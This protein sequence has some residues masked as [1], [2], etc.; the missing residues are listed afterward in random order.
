MHH[1]VN[2]SSYR[3]Y[4]FSNITW[5]ILN[6]K[7]QHFVASFYFHYISINFTGDLVWIY[8]VSYSHHPLLPPPDRETDSQPP[9]PPL[10]PL[11]LEVGA[12]RG[13]GKGAS[14]G[15]GDYGRKGKEQLRERQNNT[16][17]STRL[18]IWDGGG[19]DEPNVSLFLYQTS[20]NGEYLHTFSSILH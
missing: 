12:E 8:F 11:M 7:S 9:P 2:I 4:I 14:R 18:R 15:G 19:P 20:F 5:I 13:R 17:C 3:L 6:P 1:A 10:R 16:G